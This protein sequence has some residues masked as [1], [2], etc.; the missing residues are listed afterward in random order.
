MRRF[1]RERQ[2]FD[3]RE[4]VREVYA[5]HEFSTPDRH[6]VCPGRHHHLLELPQRHVSYR[7]LNTITCT[8]PTSKRSKNI[9]NATSTLNAP[10]S[11]MSQVF[12]E[13]ALHLS[14]I[15]TTSYLRC[16]LGQNLYLRS[17]TYDS[18]SYARPDDIV[19]R[20]IHSYI[21]KMRIFYRV[22]DRQKFTEY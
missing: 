5:L 6:T 16:L 11:R 13:R 2:I 20:E 15:S 8:I 14:H 17:N 18:G 19:D 7:Y 4:G 12:P 3:F 9:S 22:L 1:F 10:Y 21:H